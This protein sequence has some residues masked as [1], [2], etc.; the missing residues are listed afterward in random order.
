MEILILS[1]DALY[2]G[3]WRVHRFWCECIESI[4]DN[5]L[6]RFLEVIVSYPGIARRVFSYLFDLARRASEIKAH[7]LAVGT[8]EPR[9]EEELRR[10][11]K[12]VKKEMENLWDVIDIKVVDSYED[13]ILLTTGSDELREIYR[14]VI[15]ETEILEALSE[16]KQG[17]KYRG[18]VDVC[19]ELYDII[20]RWFKEIERSVMGG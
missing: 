9:E 1:F 11:E 12:Q 15:T 5:D 3:A 4:E 7:R 16:A 14:G 19:G 6:E 8:L 20:I 13:L 10:I 17:H 18:M 2:T